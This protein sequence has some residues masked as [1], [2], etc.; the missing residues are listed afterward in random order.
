MGQCLPIDKHK[1]RWD[2]DLETDELIVKI[3]LV[4]APTR[5]E[6]ASVMHSLNLWIRST[7][8]R[9]EVDNH[10]QES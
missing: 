6:V 2:Y 3:P 1:V 4:P 5:D 9:I 7:C 10:G 8:R